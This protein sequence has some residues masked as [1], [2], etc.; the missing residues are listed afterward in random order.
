MF[1]YIAQNGQTF[2][3][4]DCGV[5]ISEHKLSVENLHSQKTNVYG[6]ASMIGSNEWPWDDSSWEMNRETLVAP[7]VKEYIRQSAEYYRTSMP[8]ILTLDVM[9]TTESKAYFIE[10]NTGKGIFTPTCTQLKTRV[11]RDLLSF[12]QPTDDHGGFLP[13]G[14]CIV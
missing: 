5:R 10:C 6:G 8:Q 11:I 7:L 1:A 9:L 4:S 3:H 13:L 14:L 12:A 2:I